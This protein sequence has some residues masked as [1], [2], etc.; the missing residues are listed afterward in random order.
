ME[1]RELWLRNA[2]GFLAD[3]VSGEAVGV[4]EDVDADPQSGEVLALVVCCGWFGRRRFTVPVDEIVE[5]RPAER[6]LFLR[7]ALE[8]PR[9]RTW[10]R[11]RR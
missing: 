6:R 9:R 3:T 4:V 10:R 11:A 7:N 5:I 1:G 8:E 2:H